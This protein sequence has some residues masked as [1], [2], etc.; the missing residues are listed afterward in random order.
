VRRTVESSVE[1]STEVADMLGTHNNSTLST[2]MDRHASIKTKRVKSRP[3]FPWYTA[4]IGAAK[5]LR[6][7]SE[8]Q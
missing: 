7:I 1:T 3:S 2:L 6:R 8:G 5:R 4:E